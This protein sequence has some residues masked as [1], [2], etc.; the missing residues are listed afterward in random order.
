MIQNRI[1]FKTFLI[2]VR[3]IVTTKVKKEVMEMDTR[4]NNHMNKQQSNNNQSMSRRRTNKKHADDQAA[5]AALQPV[6]SQPSKPLIPA[7]RSRVHSSHSTVG[8]MGTAR[9]NV[10]RG[11]MSPLGL[12]SPPGSPRAQ[13]LLSGEEV[14]IPLLGKASSKKSSHKSK[15]EAGSIGFNNVTVSNSSL[16]HTPTIALSVPASV[17]NNPEQ[18]EVKPKP[19]EFETLYKEIE[20]RIIT[21][22][23]ERDG[24]LSFF[25]DTRRKQTKINFLRHLLDAADDIYDS[26]GQVKKNEFSRDNTAVTAGWG[27]IIQGL[28]DNNGEQFNSEYAIARKGFF[29]TRTAT[30]LD[31]LEKSQEPRKPSPSTQN[32]KG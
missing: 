2:I 27:Q 12:M 19:K 11:L 15:P 26:T 4:N 21:L 7:V 16:Q 8:I 31:K 3:Y 25:K 28:K 30:L 22:E 29:W 10:S 17:S 14:A 20:A 6:G 24:C 5:I 13:K 23:D 9:V 32:N 18:K 1:L